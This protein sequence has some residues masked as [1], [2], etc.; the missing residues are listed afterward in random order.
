MTRTHAAITSLFHQDDAEKLGAGG[1]TGGR[2]NR[3]D[4]HA[5]TRE[6]KPITSVGTHKFADSPLSKLLCLVAADAETE[7]TTLNT[8]T[9][10]Y[11][12]DKWMPSR[13]EAAA[14]RAK[15]HRLIR[16]R[17]N[18]IEAFVKREE[19]REQLAREGHAGES[20]YNVTAAMSAKA[21]L[22]GLVETRRKEAA[23]AE[24]NITQT[25][26]DWRKTQRDNEVG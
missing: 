22:L 10:K 11:V 9:T 4:T 26:M 3:T 2:Q 18:E 24:S 21:M 16:M 17:M 20:Q 13:S 6:N 5:A 12:N 1:A 8:V 7:L 25:H 19:A 15:A 14:K 23:V